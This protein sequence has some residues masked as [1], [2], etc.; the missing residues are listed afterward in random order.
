MQRSKKSSD[1]VLP[2][3]VAVMINVIFSSKSRATRLSIDSKE[4]EFLLKATFPLS[5]ILN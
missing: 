5:I 1:Y 2:S 4:V 3:E